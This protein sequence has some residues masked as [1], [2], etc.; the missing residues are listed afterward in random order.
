MPLCGPFIY[1]DSLPVVAGPLTDK[2]VVAGSVESMDASG[3][4]HA[5]DL[6]L[7]AVQLVVRFFP[8]AFRRTCHEFNR[9]THAFL[10]RWIRLTF[11]LSLNKYDSLRAVRYTVKLIPI[12]REALED[13]L[14]VSPAARPPALQFIFYDL[15]WI[16]TCEWKVLRRLPFN[17]HH[18]LTPC[19][20]T[21]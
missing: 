15:P 6:P 9:Y 2:L 1:L 10:L 20:G 17:R 7:S 21:T 5:V 16:T 12:L 19:R 13:G 18:G 4:G 3:D 8:I 14:S 11:L